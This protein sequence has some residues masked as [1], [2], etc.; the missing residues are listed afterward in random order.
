M[1]LTLLSSM[2]RRSLFHLVLAAGLAIASAGCATS[3]LVRLAEE[4]RHDELA[5]SID[6]E[7]ARGVLD[8]A[9][10]RDVAEAVAHAEIAAAKGSEG[11][12]RLAG[13][14]A[15]AE[16]LRSALEDRLELGDDP[17]AAAG[18]VLLSAGLVDA[19][20]Y[21]ELAS[22]AEQPPAMRALGARSLVLPEHDALR[23]SLYV[24]LE[25]AVRL[26]ALRAASTRSV[27]A[28]F[29][30]LVDALRRDP[31]AAA[32]SAAARALGALG[33]ESSVVA[34]EDAWHRADGRLRE[35]IAAA[36]AMPPSADAGGRERLRRAV[37]RGGDG[38]V[39][40]ALLL[41]RV[42]DSVP[43]GAELRATG[44]GAL[45]RAA[46]SGTRAER[47][48]A[49]V[50]APSSP[51]LSEVLREAR[52]DSDP[53]MVIVAQG[54]LGRE[55]DAAEQK[56]ARDALLELGKSDDA[57]ADRALVELAGLGDAR[58][59]EPLVKALARERSFARVYAAR[60]LVNLGALT[61]A[62]RLLGDR[63]P[64]VRLD[65]ACAVL[66]HD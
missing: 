65:V 53:S 40:A 10:T 19:D 49:L 16:A 50:L 47:A 23:R 1:P 34:L 18:Q 27:D 66:A 29:H 5:K 42:P 35:A 9:E 61:R 52:K 30:A 33:G 4:R 51:E 25:E 46:K 36:W 31:S 38:A 37:E 20:E 28:D 3:P 62:A 55:G 22:R 32:R 26:G 7:H 44:T 17:G 48:V 59:V 14:V 11:A 57:E 21:A 58:A 12:A 39:A 43:Q 45:L 15:C 41:A 2:P 63:E 54:R 24:D 8:D 6:R 56:A 64:E 60:G 13:L